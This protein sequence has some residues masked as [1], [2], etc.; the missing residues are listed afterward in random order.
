LS[1]F[2][3]AFFLSTSSFLGGGNPLTIECP[4][5]G[6]VFCGSPT[7]PDYTGEPTVSSTCPG[8]ITVTYADATLVGA[9]CAA[10]RFDSIIQ[11]TWTAVDACGNTASCTQTIDVVRQV[12]S[13][14]IKPTSCPNPINVGSNGNNAAVSIAVLGT[15]AQDVMNIDPTTIAL[16]SED[17]V[18]GPVY[19]LDFAYEDVSAPFDATARCEC[20]TA[21]PDGIVDLRLRFARLDLV[22][23]LGLAGQL[24]G[25]THRLVLSAST[26]DG[27]EL[28]ASDC[29]RIQ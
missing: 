19:A 11:R 27:C 7:T 21:G 20:T 18:T 1:T 29:V 5:T 4:G 8:D 26:Y 10:R 17:C 23:G 24:K 13:L 9:S 28:I 12:W 16:W 25:T 2:A 15:A 3:L 14:D 6:K 22:N